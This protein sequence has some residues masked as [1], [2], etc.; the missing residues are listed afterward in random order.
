VPRFSRRSARSCVPAKRGGRKTA[1][2]ACAVFRA[3]SRNWLGR[4]S[5]YW[6]AGRFRNNLALVA[7]LGPGRSRGGRLSAQTAGGPPW[8]ASHGFGVGNERVR[9]QGDSVRGLCPR[10][11]RLS[12]FR[13]VESRATL[14]RSFRDGHDRFPT[15]AKTQGSVSIAGA[16][17]MSLPSAP[18]WPTDQCPERRSVDRPAERTPVL[19]K[20]PRGH[21]S[22]RPETDRR[23]ADHRRAKLQSERRKNRGA[24]ESTTRP[25]CRFLQ[26][27]PPS[28][29]PVLSHCRVDPR[30]DSYNRSRHGPRGQS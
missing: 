15:A 23:A 2:A 9:L 17:L 26:P 10:W 13:S 28:G 11:A 27:S 6:A 19:K 20:A 25:N 30:N 24:D 4:S 14:S 16:T 1:R 5:N 18:P 29:E 22:R 3:Q 21:P 7:A 12:G 8:N